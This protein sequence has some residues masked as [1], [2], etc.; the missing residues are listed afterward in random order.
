MTPDWSRVTLEDVRRACQMYDTGA[1]RPKRPARS[2]FLLLNGKTYPAKF[3]RGLAYRLATGIE[4]D[5]N[6]D[7]SGGM[8][9]VRFF[10]GLGLATQHGSASIPA[11]PPVI[12]DA[13]PLSPAQPVPHPQGQPPSSA[14]QR[15]KEPQ[16]EAL[17]ALLR[18]QFGAVEREAKFPW[19]TVPPSDQMDG[20]ILAIYHALQGMRGYSTFASFGKP[21]FCDFFVPAERLVIEYDERQHFTVQRA[22]SLE[23]YPP[24][25]ALGFDRQEWL[26]ACRTIRA[27]DPTPPYRDEQ[28]A[29]YDSL[30]DILAARNGIRLIRL[31]YGTFDWTGP[32]AE[33]QVSNVLASGQAPVPQPATGLIAQAAAKPTVAQI[34]KVAL[35]SHNYNVADD[36][37]LYDY[38]EHFARIN[39]LCDEQGCDTIL[40]ALFTWDQDSLVVRNHDAIFGGLD[41]TQRVIL[42]VGQRGPKGIDH[43]EVWFR[44]KQD[45]LVARQ[46]FAKSSDRVA[47]KRAFMNDLP[48]RHVADGLL[49]M[50]GETNIASMLRHSDFND[51]LRFTNRLEEMKVRVILNPIHDYMTRYE[52]RKKRCRYSFGGR[53]VISV[54]NQ[55]RGREASLPWTVFYDGMERTKAVGELP[56]PFSD[57]PDIRI[58]V[59]DLTSLH[60]G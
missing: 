56:R 7:Y 6:V 12:A 54:W 36:R 53:T 48:A 32:G 9:T 38:S 51:P 29:F 30:R 4:L 11:A 16:K 27:T 1:P 60:G 17:A 35:V 23:L 52:M 57:R 31:R 28:R 33:V 20:T 34:R 8:E 13:A 49:V 2:T 22:K 21:L 3:I 10:Q 46:H 26:T 18:L 41:H 47:D 45:P 58:G 43:S 37:G 19:L 44:G 5:P 40:Y 59:L 39:K 55:G 14:P 25:L 42:E 50:C 15:R 24:D